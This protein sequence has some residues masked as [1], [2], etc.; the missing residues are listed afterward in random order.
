MKTAT[1]FALHFLLAFMPFRFCLAANAPAEAREGN[2]SRQHEVD[3]A[4]ER[5]AQFLIQAQSQ[6]GSWSNAKHP[7]ITS[8]GLLALGKA[9]GKKTREAM[10]AM[11]K[12]Y[13]FVRGQV[14]EDGGIYVEAL[15]NYNTA[16]CTLAL[17]QRGEPLDASVI[18]RARQFLVAQQANGMVAGELNGGIGY[19][20]TGVSPKRQ[21]PDLDNTLV[22]LEALRACEL[23]RKSEE[24]AALPALDWNAAI[25]FVSRC[26]NLTE[27]NPLPGISVQPADKGGFVYYPGFSNAGAVGLPDGSKALRSYGSMSYA[28]LLSFIYAEL[29]PADP[30][31]KAAHEWLDSHFT[32]E[33]NPGLGEQGLYYY[34]HL[35]ANALV[36]AGPRAES[37]KARVPEGWAADLALKLVQLQSGNGSWSNKNGRWMEADPVLATA[38]SM[39]ALELI[40]ERL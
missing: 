5:G 4:L 40:R 39:L 24:K 27:T 29:P 35:M 17:L 20:P 30:R 13:L 9:P 21:H 33:E 37:G 16:V 25:A 23:A 10:N 31:M 11:E 12:G 22:S 15:S 14:R 6:E 32:L 7:A 38:Y 1:V 26:Q 2:G 18:E 19:G 36:A 28:G 8:L 3:L 34:Y